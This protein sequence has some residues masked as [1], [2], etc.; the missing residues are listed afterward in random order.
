MDKKPY[1]IRELLH[2]L[3]QTEGVDVMI[4][5]PLSEEKP[6]FLTRLE[7]FYILCNQEIKGQ[8]VDATDPE[9]Y[10]AYRKESMYACVTEHFMKVRYMNL[11]GFVKVLQQYENL[12]IKFDYNI[13]E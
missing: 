4:Q 12:E 1:D 8:V 5:E 3:H 7:R 10:T 2:D 11:T 13:I 9:K 6:P